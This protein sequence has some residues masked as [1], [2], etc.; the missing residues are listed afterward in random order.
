ML[1][2]ILLFMLIVLSLTAF[3]VW[4]RIKEADRMDQMVLDN[5]LTTQERQHYID[6]YKKF[7]AAKMIYGAT[8]GDKLDIEVVQALIKEKRQ[9]Q[10]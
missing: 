1:F 5:L 6:E 7:I 2:Y 3:I 10:K 8:R 4:L 9:E